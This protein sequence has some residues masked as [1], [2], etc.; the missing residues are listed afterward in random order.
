MEPM[1]G[2]ESVPSI[3]QKTKPKGAH[4]FMKEDGVLSSFRPTVHSSLPHAPLWLNP[5]LRLCTVTVVQAVHI[6]SH[7]SLFPSKYQQ[8]MTDEQT[9]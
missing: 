9:V 3:A 6:T 2:P 8:S 1:Q 4:L 5:H 7:T